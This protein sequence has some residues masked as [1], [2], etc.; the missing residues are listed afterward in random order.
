MPRAPK[1]FF[2]KLL[3]G[4]WASSA[5]DF[6]DRIRSANIIA[7]CD[8]LEDAEDAAGE[9]AKEFR[10]AVR[11]QIKSLGNCFGVRPDL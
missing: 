4:D 1:T 11:Y 6:F 10:K 9:F 7:L 3:D 5:E 8:L 2:L